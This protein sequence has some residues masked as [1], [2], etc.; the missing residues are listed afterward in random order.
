MLASH[1]IEYRPRDGSDV[2]QDWPIGYL[3]CFLYS[4][5]TN[6]LPA[7]GKKFVL[8]PSVLSHPR[9]LVVSGH[10]MGIRP[11]LAMSQEL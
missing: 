1:N 6:N 11:D 8:R 10:S 4:M 7:C 5:S 2:N 3:R 9:S